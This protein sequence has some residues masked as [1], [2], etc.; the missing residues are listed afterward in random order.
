[1]FRSDRYSY[2]DDQVGYYPPLRAGENIAWAVEVD[3]SDISVATWNARRSS[4]MDD[5]QRRQLVVPDRVAHVR[6]QPELR[7]ST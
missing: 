4:R 5:A 6:G 2:D 3:V 7:E 1:M